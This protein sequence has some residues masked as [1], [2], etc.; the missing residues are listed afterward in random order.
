MDNE[1]FQELVL[2]QLG[3]L[4]TGQQA[5]QSDIKQLQSGQQA[6]QSD[7]QQLQSGQQ[8]MQS[9]IQQ[10]QSGQQAMQSDIQ[11]LQ[12]EQQKNHQEQRNIWTCLDTLGLNQNLIRQDIATIRNDVEYIRQSQVRVENDFSGKIKALFD[13]K[14]NQIKTNEQ[15]AARLD[16]LEAK[17]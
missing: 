2:E 13:F 14:D 16:R 6:M 1:K 11:Q 17:M 3:S 12:S 4:H 8:A 15:V 10:L 7:I 9:D 5:M